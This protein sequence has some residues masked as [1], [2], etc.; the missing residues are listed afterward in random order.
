MFVLCL[1]LIMHYDNSI[2]L[3]CH[4]TGVQETPSNCYKFQEELLENELEG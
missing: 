2:S 3:R 4:Q 1:Y